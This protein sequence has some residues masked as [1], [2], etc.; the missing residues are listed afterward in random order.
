[1]TGDV[2]SMTGYG[3][4]V[5]DRDGRRAVVEIRS[6]NHRFLDLKLRG[7]SVDP[8]VEARVTR[9]V[10]DRL[11]RG[12]VTVTVR[13]EA[14][15]A[16]AALTVDTDAAR[17]VHGELSALARDLEIA[18]PVPLSLVCAQPGVMVPKESDSDEA[19]IA[20]CVLE[21]LTEAL[22]G[23]V[24]MRATEGGTLASDLNKRLGR[25][26][27]L[28]GA[29]G[30]LVSK[31]PDEAKRRLETRLERLMQGSNVEIEPE[32][33][34]QEVAVVADR[35][36]VT[37]ELV[38]LGSHFEQAATVAAEDGAI[39]RRMDFLAQE[40]GRELNTIASKSQSAKIAATVVEAKAELEK[41]REQIQN[42]E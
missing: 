29:L 11:L 30:E 3:R 9:A 14:R 39:G 19:I 4:G 10:R 2:R 18:E 1:M 21:A 13:I 26:T 40:M 28:V 37:E 6:V 22:D 15:G 27:E 41:V 16:A 42:V 8:A 31:A 12:A 25:L 33:L 36:D 24:A 38:R 20:E 7:A 32:R 23:L 5:A 35:V 17:R 34:A